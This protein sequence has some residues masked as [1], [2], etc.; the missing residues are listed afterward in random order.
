M[1]IP[2]VLA[3][4]FPAQGHVIPLMEV[5]KRLVDRGIRV[6]FVNT[7]FV[8][9]RV[10]DALTDKDFLGDSIHLVSI[11]DG[12]GPGE[13]RN[14]L[15]LLAEAMFQV[16][17]GKLAE[18]IR[19]TEEKEGEK[20][21]CVLADGSMEWALEVAHKMNI[22]KAAFW[23]ASV[24]LFASGLSIPKMISDG[25]INDEGVAIK[26][27]KFQ[28]A[29]GMPDMSPANLTWACIGDVAT[30]KIIFNVMVRV[31][32]SMELADWFIGNT[33]CDLEPAA[34]AF[35]HR[36]LPIGPLLANHHLDSS[37]GYFWP[38]DSDC[39][40]WLD[41]QAPKSVI[42]VAFGSFTVFDQTQFQ[43]L[44]LGLELSQRPFLWV[45]RPDTTEERDDAYPKGFK[46]RISGRGKLVGWAPQQKVLAHPAI[47]CFVSH[48]GWNS[49]MEGASNG[50]PFL[51]W[52]YFAD[53]FIDENYICDLWRVGLGFNRDESGIIRREEIKRKV[54]QLL[55]DANFGKRASDI[56]EKLAKGIVEGGESHK[57]FSNFVQWMKA[58]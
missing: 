14:D 31:I 37:A 11:P 55:D 41:Q 36:V 50:I 29:P 58:L 46:E 43:E 57:N 17:P 51:C 15:G 7:D 25:I 53:Q 33:S 49:T 52:P 19:K 28:L 40:I 3:I 20:I 10:I 39:L 4:P 24:A 21:T 12:L 5:S 35:A 23:P 2:H 9:K 47:A 45:V 18:L 13:D 54:D 16:M 1:S 38:E 8:H 6:T 26:H 56:K 22:P 42:Y 27:Q 44:A 34:L 48:C 30:Q 32:K